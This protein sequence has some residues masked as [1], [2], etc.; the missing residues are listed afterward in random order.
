MHLTIESVLAERGSL[1]LTYFVFSD[2][3]KK[4]EENKRMDGMPRK[5]RWS[6]TQ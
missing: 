3:K 5:M 6:E 4:Q 2:S 1:R